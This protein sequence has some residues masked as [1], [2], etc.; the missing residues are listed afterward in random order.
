MLVVFDIRR[1][2]VIYLVPEHCRFIGLTDEIMDD[3]KAFREVRFTRRTDAPIK[4]KESTQFVQ[5]LMGHDQ[6]LPRMR[7]WSFFI[8]PK[9]LEFP[10][11]KYGAGNVLMG[12]KARA[13]LFNSAS[14]MTDPMSR[15][16]NAQQ[17]ESKQPERLKFSIE[18]KGRDLNLS[19]TKNKL[20]DQP[21][22][23][24]WGIFYQSR[25]H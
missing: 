9:V 16:A 6:V 12:Q 5:V 7:A 24:K 17:E 8:E 2:Q 11:L 18:E 4:V 20:F 1:E 23:Q 21:V 14:S 15:M 3:F 13:N 10:G 19:L 22:I 25:D